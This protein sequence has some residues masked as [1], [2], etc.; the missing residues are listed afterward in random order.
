[1]SSFDVSPVGV[2]RHIMR[3]RTDQRNKVYRYATLHP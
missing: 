2:R 3:A 1:M